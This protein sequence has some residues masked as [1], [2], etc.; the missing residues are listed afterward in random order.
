MRSDPQ[1]R[2]RTELREYAK[3]MT[4]HKQRA[5]RAAILVIASLIAGLFALV[6]DAHVAS[7]ATP[8][9]GGSLAVGEPISDSTWTSLDP[10]TDI[11]CCD[12]N[13]KQSI[14]GSLFLRVATKNGGSTLMP[15]LATGYRYENNNETIVINLRHGV[16][17]TDGTPFNADAVAY[18]WN[19]DLSTTCACKTSFLQTAPPV[20]QVVSPYSV[21]LT[22]TYPDPSFISGL[23]D[24]QFSFIGSPTAEKSMSEQAFAAKPVGAGPFVV[25]SNT[26]GTQLVLKRNP[27][28]WQ[29][30]HPY[31][32]TLTF[33]VLGS[34]ES[35][36]EAMKAGS[37]QADEYVVTTSLIPTF[38][39]AGF[40]VTPEPVDSEMAVQFNTRVPPFNN[41]QARKAIFYA[42][43]PQ[44]LDKKLQDNLT[45]VTES[46]IE[47]G[48]L[49]FTSQKIPGTIHYNLAKAKSLVR[50]LGGLSFTLM[51]QNL[52]N[53]NTLEQGLES[54]WTQAGMKVALSSSDFA[55]L[56]HLYFS[57]TWQIA[58]HYVG[59]LDPAI[60]VGPDLMFGPN[61]NGNY[62][63]VEDP[64]LNS[65]LVQASETVN[66]ATRKSLYYQ[67]SKLIAQKAYGMFLYPV[68]G[69]NIVAK[70]V[71]GPGLTTVVP[72]VT[73]KSDILW[74][75]V[76]NNNV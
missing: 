37:I 51:T 15:D 35:G 42:T 8:H 56:Q 70:G 49:F 62:S 44:L 47:K 14:F 40:K 48:G 30:G 39:S 32:N 18:N 16:T 20:I 2:H 71:G 36:F 13:Y 24:A 54:E 76:Y 31:L 59:A 9:R 60:G 50:S 69:A 7:A 17:F 23:S 57:K 68:Y 6:T 45:P 27:N 3:H 74:Q 72:A 29:K 21:S 61:L 26:P 75:D 55:S 66:P 41:I 34:D 25:A 63:G 19:R 4:R 53:L 12:Y 5:Q 65:I 58:L 1:K 38:K 52:S 11:T 33:K 73:S 64:T 67:A 46:F 10:A 22:L 28:Y 43:N